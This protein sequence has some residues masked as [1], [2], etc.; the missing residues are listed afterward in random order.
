MTLWIAWSL[1]VSALIAIAALAIERSAAF[2]GAP[3]RHIWILALTAAAVVPLAIA[4]RRAPVIE[5][6]PSGAPVATSPAVFSSSTDGYTFVVGIETPPLPASWNVAS[7]IRRIDPWVAP[8]WLFAS[9]VYLTLLSRAVITLRAQRANWIETD[10]EVGRV[11]VARDAGPAVVGVLRPRIV[12]PRWA[13]EADNRARA[14]LLRHEYEHLRAGDSRVLFAVAVVQALFPWNIAIAFMARRLRLAIEIDCDSRVVRAGS[15]AHAYGVMLLSVGERYSAALPHSAA[16]SEPGSHLEARINAMTTPLPRR[17]L[18][19]SLPLAGIALLALT[20]ASAAPRPE[21]M[22]KQRVKVE[23]SPAI[24][25]PMSEVRSDE[26][27]PPTAAGPVAE[28]PVFVRGALSRGTGSVATP[29]APP[30]PLVGNPAP[31]YPDE[32]RSAGAEGQVLLTFSTN[33][34]GIPDTATIRVI[35]STHAAF[36]NAVRRV[37]PAWRYD[38]GGLVHFACRFVLQGVGNLDSAAGQTVV[39]GVPVWPVVITALPTSQRFADPR[40]LPGNPG[41]RY[42]DVFRGNGTEGRVLA[43]FITDSAGK[44]ILSTFEVVESTHD[45]F[46]NSVKQHFTLMRFDSPGLVRLSFRFTMAGSEATERNRIAPPID[47][48]DGVPVPGVFITGVPPRYE[49]L[50]VFGNGAAAGS[51]VQRQQV[52]IPNTPAGRVFKAWLEAINSGDRKRLETFAEKF[53][54]DTARRR[55]LLM[56][57]DEHGPMD[58]LAVRE[59]QEASLEFVVNYRQTGERHVGYFGLSSVEPP[60]LYSLRILLVNRGRTDEDPGLLAHLRSMRP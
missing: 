31:R 22:L 41:P 39:E 25:L 54:A 48:I 59:S 8:L 38:S 35:G 19:A 45:M 23:A 43:K 30:R 40:P 9:L 7:A 3:R 4:L 10:S 21:P 17:P 2:Y 49:N 57:Y 37:L 16:L 33:A 60:T 46:T 58:L 28:R 44:P 32:M 36:T 29:A 53:T 51:S 47:S 27:S 13:L 50:Q 52:A 1:L 56:I 20:M 6:L 18:A 34:R 26:H 15:S 14:L 12:I 11:F 5:P 24:T 55:G 42:P